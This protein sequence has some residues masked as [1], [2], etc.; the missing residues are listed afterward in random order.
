M[1][2]GHPEKDPY[3]WMAAAAN[4]LVSLRRAILQKGPLVDIND[5]ARRAYDTSDPRFCFEKS[6]FD[7]CSIP[8]VYFIAADYDTAQAVFLNAKRELDPVAAAFASLKVPAANKQYVDYTDFQGQRRRLTDG[9]STALPA[10]ELLERF[11]P[12]HVLVIPNR[13]RA[14]LDRV[15]APLYGLLEKMVARRMPGPMQQAFISRART[16]AEGIHYLLAA[17]KRSSG[18]PSLKVAIAWPREIVSPWVASAHQ[19]RQ[20]ARNSLRDFTYLLD[21]AEHLANGR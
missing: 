1:A 17:R 5:V 19:V 6:G 12:S 20:A 16:F 8:E 14:D 21:R 18:K 7:R 2:A 3:M 13:L 11:N 9:G 15:P 4:P 10:A